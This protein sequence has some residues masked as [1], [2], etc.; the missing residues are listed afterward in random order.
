MA[1]WFPHPPS[2]DYFELQKIWAVLAPQKSE[3]Y[4]LRASAW[5]GR[6]W[7][8]EE[9]PYSDFCVFDFLAGQGKSPVGTS[10]EG[11]DGD[12]HSRA[13]SGRGL[14]QVVDLGRDEH[15][16]ASK[17]EPDSSGPHSLV[18]EEPVWDRSCGSPWERSIRCQGTRGL[19]APSLLLNLLSLSQGKEPRGMP[20]AWPPIY[21][22]KCA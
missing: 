9:K 3:R 4:C 2:R 1:P 19:R 16:E 5:E 14:T 21:L 13:D 12:W 6:H 15:V 11:R 8:A 7:E 18:W 10:Q 22:R 17:G 20:G